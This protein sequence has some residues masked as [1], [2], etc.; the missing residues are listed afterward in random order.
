MTLVA[1]IAELL[2]ARAEHSPD[3]TCLLASGRK[4]LTYADLWEQCRYVEAE[5]RAA[6]F[7]PESCIAAVLPT[8]AEAALAFQA[9]GELHLCAAESGRQRRWL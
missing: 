2:R 8:S 1:T 7:G 5:L 3:A 9:R 6:G 4:P